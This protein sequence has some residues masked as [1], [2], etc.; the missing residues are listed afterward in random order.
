MRWLFLFLLSLNLAY[1]AWEMSKAPSEDY[2]N[3]PALKNVET[4]VLLKELKQSQSE[5]TSSG[6]KIDGDDVNTADTA[7]GSQSD[8]GQAGTA[9]SVAS[10]KVP[11]TSPAVIS[12]AES[13]N[14][15]GSASQK[16][17]VDAGAQKAGGG[18]EMSAKSLPT[19]GCY[20]LGPFRDLDKLRGLTREIKSYVNK[21]EFRGKEETEPTIY[22]VYLAPETSRRK[23]IETGNRLKA[24]KIKDFYVIRE[25]EKENGLSLGHFRNKKR[26]YALAKKVTALGFNTNVEPVYKTYTAYWLDYEL[27]A[28]AVIPEAVFDKYI[29]AGGKDNISRLSRDCGV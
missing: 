9:Q 25:G 1:I 20:T 5:S 29:G 22:W 8:A 26:A 15:A 28:G 7:I 14:L 21:A 2:A 19:A 17:T 18:E 6:N 4:I 23:A 10:E 3:V 12:E 13:K 11:E 16:N 24:K 27:A